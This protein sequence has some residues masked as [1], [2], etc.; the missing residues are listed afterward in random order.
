[1]TE[2]SLRPLSSSAA[3][4]HCGLQPWLVD[5]RLLLPAGDLVR[6]LEREADVIEAFEEAHAGG[7]RAL[8]R[9]IGSAGSAD[10]LR[11]E[12]DREWSGAVHRNHPLLEGLRV[13][14][15]EH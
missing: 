6:V 2:S 14:R 12:I 10:A 1:M 11:V 3:P 4:V 13:R 15:R 5:R 7:G 8:E 9:H